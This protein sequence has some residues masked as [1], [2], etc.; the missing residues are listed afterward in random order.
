[1]SFVFGSDTS[2]IRRL[3]FPNRSFQS[4]LHYNLDGFD[5]SKGEFNLFLIARGYSDSLR[6]I[7]SLP[8][9]ISILKPRCFSSEQEFF[10]IAST[11]IENF[12][13]DYWV[14]N[15]KSPYYTYSIDSPFYLSSKNG[16]TLDNETE[17][18]L[19]LDSMKRFL[20]SLGIPG[21]IEEV[22][23]YARFHVPRILPARITKHEGEKKKKERFLGIPFI[24][25]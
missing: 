23:T 14:R 11:H 6:H 9:T 20:E 15:K 12:G 25:G 17:P 13:R 7:E 10:K 21:S 24:R 4:F 3:D 8:G 16:Q 5:L 18:H 19:E 1:Y 22:I 2:N